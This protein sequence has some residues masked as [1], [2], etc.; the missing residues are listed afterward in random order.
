ME[1]RKIE[2]I[3]V[4]TVDSA[5]VDKTRKNET[6]YLW[7]AWLGHMSYLKLK[8]MVEKSRIKGLSNIEVRTDIVY[9]GC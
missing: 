3:Y 1:A 5:Y 6:S 7:H 9:T 2:S 4:M 8:L